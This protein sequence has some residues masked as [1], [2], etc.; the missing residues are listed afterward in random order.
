MQKYLFLFLLH[1]AQYYVS[2]DYYFCSGYYDDDNDGES[3]QSDE[4]KCNIIL[5]DMMADKLT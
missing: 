5:A 1:N 2:I 3:A 4:I